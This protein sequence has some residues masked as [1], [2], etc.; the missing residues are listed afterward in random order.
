ML[1]GSSS[2][3]IAAREKPRRP[4]GRGD[5]QSGRREKF[6]HP[7]SRRTM[8]PGNGTNGGTIFTKVGHGWAS[9]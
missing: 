1:A 5:D 3:N 7:R 9:R 2:T 8:K 4:A 6:E